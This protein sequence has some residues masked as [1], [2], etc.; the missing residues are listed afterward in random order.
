[1]ARNATLED[2]VSTLLAEAEKE[3]GLFSDRTSAHKWWTNQFR[4]T[5]SCL[6]YVLFE[7]MR[8]LALKGTELAEPKSGQ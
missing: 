1:M 2:K 7:R 6:A 3:L 5:I 4:I 8:N